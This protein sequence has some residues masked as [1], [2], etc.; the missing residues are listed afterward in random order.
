MAVLTLEQLV[1]DVDRLPPLPQVVLQV[2]QLLEDPHIRAEDLA[3]AIRMD[4]DLTAQLLRLSNSAYYGLRREITSIKEAVAILGLKTLKSMIYTILSHQVLDTPVEG[5]LLDRGALW[6]NALA[7]A[8]FAR[9]LAQHYQYPEPDTAFTAAILRD[10]G[11]VVLSDYVGPAYRTLELYS[12]DEKQGFNEAEQSLLGFSHTQVGEQLA[13]K[14]NFPQKLT[15]AIGYHH[16]PSALP[17]DTT[18]ADRL[19]VTVIHM[20]DSFTMM[21]G[22]GVGS[23][24]LMYPIDIPA[25]EH[26]GITVNNEWV[27]TTMMALLPLQAKAQGLSTSMMSSNNTVA[28]GQSS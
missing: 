28:G 8:E 15:L 9:H 6:L 24:G 11:K 23:D 7:G 2:S 25:L 13:R 16:T 18:E 3:E 12:K 27:E 14:W 4:A 26:I 22:I 19:L 21:L 5:Y 20:A 1:H 17:L 10:L